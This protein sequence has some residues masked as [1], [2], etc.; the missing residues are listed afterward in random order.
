MAQK[1]PIPLG[2]EA[3]AHVLH[4][5]HIAAGGEK[6]RRGDVAEAVFVIRGTLK[7]DGKSPGDRLGVP[8]GSVDVHRQPHPIA[9]RNRH[10][11][12]DDDVVLN[13]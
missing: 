3:S 2:L 11:A 8:G 1:D 5:T 6:S 13:R 7:Q 4:D 10:V 9:H 12:L